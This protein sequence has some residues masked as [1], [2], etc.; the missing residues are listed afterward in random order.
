MNCVRAAK[1]VLAGQV[2]GSSFY[3]RGQFDGA[4]RGPV[5][6]PGVFRRSELV[7]VQ[8]VI[9]D[10]GR[11][12]GANLRVRQPARQRRIAPVPQLDGE[13]SAGFA[14]Q[15][16]YQGAG[17]EIDEGHRQRRWSL[18]MSDTGRL[19]RGRSRPAAV[20]RR[21]DTSRPI[22]P[23][24]ASRC[25]VAVAD[26]PSSRATGTP[27]SVTTTSSPS[28]TRSSQSLRCARSSV[29]G[30]SIPKVYIPGFVLLYGRGAPLPLVDAGPGGGRVVV[31]GEPE[32][33]LE[34][35]ETGLEAWFPREAVVPIGPHDLQVR[36]PDEAVE[37]VGDHEHAGRAPAQVDRAED[38]PGRADVVKHVVRA[39]L[40]AVSDP[41]ADRV[42]DA[43]R[44][45]HR[46]AA[47]HEFR[48]LAGEPHPDA[49]GPG[50]HRAV[51]LDAGHGPA[52]LAD[53]AGDPVHVG[54]MVGLGAR[55]LLSAVGAP[56]VVPRGAAGMTLRK[57]HGRHVTPGV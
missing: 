18:T 21:A 5:P 57:V 53:R 40:R 3:R 26:M 44:V 30:T 46:G 25:K 48:G 42:D 41:G 47:D 11:Q 35:V 17:I 38:E 45:A 15:K 6:L 16:L 10:G 4:N 54:Q 8:V 32:Q 43:G 33:R 31:A 12:C 29:T 22:T 37:L 7:V 13:L 56:G 34:A 50:R 14:D 23:S 36:R 52:V 55:G 49:V 2:P 20:G 19:A 39:E 28:R 27:R 9:V 1:A 24:A 51:S